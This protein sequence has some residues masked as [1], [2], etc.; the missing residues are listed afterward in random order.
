MI[1]RRPVRFIGLFVLLL[2]FFGGPSLVRF[3][4]DWL[5]FSEVGYQSVFTTMLRIQGTLFTIVFVIAFV[6]LA[7]NFRVAVASTVKKRLTVRPFLSCSRTIA[8]RKCP[9]SS[10]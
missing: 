6:W 9:H 10:I 8:D 2:L 5:W 1:M 4:T 7:L 3:Y